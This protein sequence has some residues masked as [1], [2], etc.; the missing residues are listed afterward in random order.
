[1][2]MEL[3]RKTCAI[4]RFFNFHPQSASS[5]VRTS[6][7]RVYTPIRCAESGGGVRLV[8][9][10]LLTD[11]WLKMRP[12]SRF[13]NLHPQTTSSTVRTSVERVHTPIRGA[14]CDGIVSFGVRSLYE[15]LWRKTCP[16]LGFF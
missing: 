16:I 1:M 5:T 9:R 3:C 4:L 12:I 13:V 10:A 8:V 11:I 15:Q 6:V 14:E 7:E 2:F